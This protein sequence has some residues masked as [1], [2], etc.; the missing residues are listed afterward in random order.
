MNRCRCSWHT[1]VTHTTVFHRPRNFPIMA[2]TTKLAIDDLSHGDFVA[3]RLERKAKVSMTNLATKTKSGLN[4]KPVVTR[5][6]WLRS[7]TENS[8][9]LATMVK[10]PGRWRTVVCAIPGCL[11]HQLQF[12]EVQFKDWS[13]LPTKRLALTKAEKNKGD[14]GREP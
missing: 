14:R 11:V 13:R 2:C 7:S 8:A 4:L 12:M 3:T 6:L 9:V 1:G 10:F 5:S